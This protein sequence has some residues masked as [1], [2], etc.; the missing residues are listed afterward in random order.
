MLP[1]PHRGQSPADAPTPACPQHPLH[2]PWAPWPPSEWLFPGEGDVSGSGKHQHLQPATHKP[3]GDP[4]TSSTP[5]HF[6]ENPPG[7]G[8][9]W[10]SI[11]PAALNIETWHLPSIPR[12]QDGLSRL[13]TALPAPGM[14]HTLFPSS[15]P[16]RAH[17]CWREQ[18]ASPRGHGTTQDQGQPSRWLV[19]CPRHWEQPA[20][21]PVPVDA[22]CHRSG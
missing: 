15:V 2:S 19:P 10:A 16:I 3:S 14:L 8:L 7:V 12:C 22:T 5:S 13:C 6:G 18:R 20:L 11:F 9:S 4:G 21:S 1:Q 17:S